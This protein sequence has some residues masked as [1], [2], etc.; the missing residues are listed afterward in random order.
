[1]SMTAPPEEIEAL[2]YVI[3]ND[4]DGDDE[5]LRALRQAFRENVSLPADAL[6]IAEPVA[7]VEI[8]YDGNRRRG[9]TAR[10]ARQD[11]SEHVVAAS[12]V[13]FADGSEGARYVA[14]YRRWLSLEPAPAA[15]ADPKGRPRRHKV[16]ANELD[17][18]TPIELVVLAP[19]ERAARCRILGSEREIT[20]R[21]GDVW[22][23]VPGE[24]I[25]VRARKQWCY[26]GHPYLSGDVESHRLDVEALGLLP[27]KLRDEWQ[28][29]PSEEYWGGEGEPRAEWATPIVAAGPRS[30]FEMEQVHPGA[31]PVDW[32]SDPVLEAS[33]LHAAGDR[34]GARKLLVEM[35]A[36]D[37]RC[38]GAH[39]H[40]GN[41]DF[42]Q[43][44]EDAMRH[45]E[46]GV[47][48]GELSLGYDFG[49]VLPWGRI[50][51]RPFLRCM[52]GLGLCFWRLGRREE[53][54]ALF[55]R[56]LW[57]NPTDNQGIRFLLAQVR[58]G[59]RWENLH[60]KG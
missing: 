39:A 37:L 15:M 11:G 33:E 14:A 5:Q 22:N 50:D 38:L 25:T 10:C 41:L 49:G 13:C 47:R 31:D 58:A 48:I 3:L 40:L 34:L 16:A 53:A 23:M 26:A 20:L 24:I 27:L 51:N 52:H 29:D 57:L 54:T 18:D 32:V 43:H 46:A 60:G 8:G 44:P 45:Y 30:S 7:V 4:A 35:L 55:K 42:D 21:S 36:V 9:L 28:C 59:E 1:M 17:L 2:L 12:E 6:V 19:K 56:M